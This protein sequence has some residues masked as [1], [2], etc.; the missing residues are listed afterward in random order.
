MHLRPRPTL[1]SRSGALRF[2]LLLSVLLASLALAAAYSETGGPTEDAAFFDTPDPALIEL[3][4]ATLDEPTSR[5]TPEPTPARAV[6]LRKAVAAGEVAVS[7]F[8]DGL[9]RLEIE[10]R[11]KVE[12]PIRVVVNPGTVFDA[13]RSATQAMVVTAKE[14]IA[15]EPGATERT[16][17]EVACSEMDKDQPGDDDRFKLVKRTLPKDLT[18]LLALEDFPNADFRMQQFAIW[19]I[20]DDPSRDGFVQLGSFGVGSGPSSKEIVA[21]RELFAEA[22]ID[23]D[24]YRATR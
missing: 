3:D 2:G 14:V 19:T 15:L 4:E 1:P 21:I 8:G 23:P 17:L 6:E 22:G 16:T 13:A 9:E 24:T 7:G 12:E 18:A 10:L 5:P 11:S 20:L